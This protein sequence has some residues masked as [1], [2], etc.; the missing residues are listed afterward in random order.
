[1]TG[2][3]GATA[4]GVAG[5]FVDLQGRGIAGVLI[6]AEDA[7][8]AGSNLA[9][10]SSDAGGNFLLVGLPATKITLRFDATPANP[11]FPIWPFTLT[12]EAGKI[13]P[14]SDWTLQP[15]PRDE[16]FKPLIANHSADQIIAGDAGPLGART[17]RRHDSGLGWR[18]QVAHGDRT[19]RSRQVADR[20]R[21][22][23][24]DELLPH[25]LRHARW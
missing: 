18:C 19:R 20:S 2:A 5:R 21:A 11:G 3:A 8:V 25:L 16:L 6:R 15:P 13:T 1:M 4:A 9:Q 7:E 14:L 17:R 22:E 12:L 10:T 24:R 23:R